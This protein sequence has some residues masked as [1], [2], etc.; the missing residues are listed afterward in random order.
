MVVCAVDQWALAPDQ[1]GGALNK[2]LVRPYC[3]GQGPIY[4]RSC[5]LYISSRSGKDIGLRP[6]ICTVKIKY[7]LGHIYFYILCIVVHF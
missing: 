1:S 5:I 2:A 6:C 7:I 3:A 4:F